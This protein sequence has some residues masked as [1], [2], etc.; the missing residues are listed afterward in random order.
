MQR[1]F[2]HPCII[3]WCG[4]NETGDPLTDRIAPLTDLTYV[5]Y[6]AAKAMDPTRPVLDA[7][8]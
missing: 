3:G 5:C 8:G 1:D 2:S 4:L 6:H 7:S